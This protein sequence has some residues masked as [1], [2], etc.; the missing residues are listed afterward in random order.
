MS[1]NGQL[2]V[3]KPSTKYKQLVLNILLLTEDGF[4]YMKTID[5]SKCIRRYIDKQ[6]EKEKAPEIVARMK[7]DFT[8][9]AYQ[10]FDSPSMYKIN[11]AI[12]DNMDVCVEFRPLTP[13]QS[14][15]ATLKRHKSLEKLE[16]VKNEFDR[17]ATSTNKSKRII[18]QLGQVLKD[19]FM[20]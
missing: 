3:L 13:L 15:Q 2:F 17:L 14:R 4:E 1:N 18:S 20:Q 8:S 5:I 9:G 19:K 6:V 16:K 12:N 7:K 10:S 11:F